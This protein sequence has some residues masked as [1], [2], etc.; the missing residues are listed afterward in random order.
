MIRLYKDPKGHNIFN[1]ASSS[2]SIKIGKRGVLTVVK[3]EEKVA[4][5][6]LELDELNTLIEQKKVSII[7]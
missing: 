4:S 5:L 6:K 7:I 2:A 1:H 3:D